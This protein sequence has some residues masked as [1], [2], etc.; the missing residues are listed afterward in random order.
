MEANPHYS[1]CGTTT[2]IRMALVGE[3]WWWS[4]GGGVVVV[5]VE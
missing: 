5:V 3:E 1:M 2:P 4:G